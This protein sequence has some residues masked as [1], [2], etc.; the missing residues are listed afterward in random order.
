MKIHVIAVPRGDAPDEI[1]QAWVGL[2]LPLAEGETGSRAFSSDRLCTS[3]R[4][5]LW[6]LWLVLTWRKPPDFR[7]YIVDHNVAFET[8]SRA[9]PFA[10]NWWR[11][12]RPYLF[13][14]KLKV[15]FYVEECELI[16]D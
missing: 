12:N 9:S 11:E 14:Q 2:T 1:R 13:E 8:L 6:Y 3:L 7:V 10:L 4:S 16:E 5:R 15:A